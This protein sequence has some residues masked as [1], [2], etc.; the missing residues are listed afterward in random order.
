LSKTREWLK[1]AIQGLAERTYVETT[2]IMARYNPFFEKAGMTKI[3]ETKPNSPVLKAIEK[4]RDSGFNPVLLSSTKYN[5]KQLRTK[6]AIACEVRRILKSMSKKS[7][8]IYRKR[9]AA[10]HKACVK[11]QE[12]CDRVNSASLE[13]L[14]KMLRVISI[15]AQTK[16]YLFWKNP[17]FSIKVKTMHIK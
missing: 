11:H 10:V 3:A 6:P 16:V 4:L 5:L 15:L 13:K 17:V 8:G 7:G 2:A 1:M 14:A 9:I 12:F